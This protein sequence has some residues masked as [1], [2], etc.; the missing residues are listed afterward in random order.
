ML[1]SFDLPNNTVGHYYYHH[2]L[3]FIDEKTNL[4]EVRKLA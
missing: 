2:R 3:F 4:R 1:F